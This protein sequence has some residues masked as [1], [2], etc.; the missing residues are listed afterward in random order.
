MT[1]VQKLTHAKAGILELAGL[2]GIVSSACRVT[3][4]CAIASTDLR[5]RTIEAVKLRCGR[6]PIAGRCS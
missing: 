1:P 4:Y 3:G 2:L 6:F 5:N